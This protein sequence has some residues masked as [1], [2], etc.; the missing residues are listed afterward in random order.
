MMALFAVHI[1]RVSRFVHMDTITIH[2]IQHDIA[3]ISRGHVYV[4]RNVISG[5][6]VLT[7]SNLGV[8]VILSIITI[9]MIIVM[10]ETMVVVLMVVVTMAITAR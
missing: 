1:S 8:L 3:I 7:I 9:T 5:A 10:A 4:I 6:V 2:R